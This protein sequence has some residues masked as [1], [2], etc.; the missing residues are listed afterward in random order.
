M[1]I[2]DQK[3][4][5]TVDRKGLIQTLAN[6]LETRENEEQIAHYPLSPKSSKRVFQYLIGAGYHKGN[7]PAKD[8][9]KAWDRI[10]VA[11]DRKIAKLHERRGRA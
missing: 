8:N 10:W 1:K 2:E 4:L 9:T 7:M 5:R 3:N 11:V 6:I